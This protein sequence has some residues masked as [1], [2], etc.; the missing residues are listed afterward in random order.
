MR[1][2]PCRSVSMRSGIFARRGSATICAQRSRLNL[3]CDLRSG[4]SIVIGTLGRYASC[5][6]GAKRIELVASLHC[7][8]SPLPARRQ[9]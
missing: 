4:S 3:V 9:R 8:F 5:G 6:L 2:C 7:L 1:I